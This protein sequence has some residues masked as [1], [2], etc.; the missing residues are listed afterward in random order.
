VLKIL[1]YKPDVFIRNRVCMTYSD[2]KVIVTCEKHKLKIQTKM[3]RKLSH[4]F[5]C[6]LRY[7]SPSCHPGEIYNRN[8]LICMHMYT[9]VLAS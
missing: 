8:K 9:G 2:M 5:H 6:M 1:E 7:A 3:K 4:L